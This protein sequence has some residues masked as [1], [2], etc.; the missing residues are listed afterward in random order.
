[1]GLLVIG[2]PHLLKDMESWF[3]EYQSDR[4]PP[5]SFNNVLA[6]SF[7]QPLVSL[8]CHVTDDSVS[9]V[10]DD[11]ICLALR[12]LKHL[13]MTAHLQTLMALLLLDPF[14]TDLT[15]LLICPAL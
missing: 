15:S 10:A 11:S 2:S 3:G 9:P 5:I 12:H 1:M 4:A 6:L 13:L 8:V 14:L 7:C